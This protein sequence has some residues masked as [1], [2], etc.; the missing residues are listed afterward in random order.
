MVS[1]SFRRTLA[2]TV[3]AALVG[4]G[5][6]AWAA[7]DPGKK[8]CI[9]DARLLC[10]AEMRAMSRKRVQACLIARI[11]KTSP[12]CHSTMLTLKAEAEARQLKR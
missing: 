6:L 4:T 12:L 11:D 8:A 9:A 3:A 10:P 1:L 2:F 7:P 5:S